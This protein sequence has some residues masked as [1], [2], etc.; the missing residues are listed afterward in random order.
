M[1]E[2][3]EE[4]KRAIGGLKCTAEAVDRLASARSAGR[5]IRSA[6]DAWLDDNAHV[7]S[8]CIDAIGSEEHSGPG[9]EDLARARTMLAAAVGAKS[10]TPPRPEGP[11]SAVCS[12][13]LCSWAETCADVD[14]EAASW[15]SAGAP[16]GILEHRVNAGV[17][18]V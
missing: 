6:S 8:M 3:A 15:A 2:K 7:E 16:A 14:F 11:R 13:I 9:P 5:R 12:D 4:N 1:H 18:P 10:S 17:F